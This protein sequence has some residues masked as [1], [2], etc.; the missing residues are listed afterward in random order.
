V[1]LPPAGQVSWSVRVRHEVVD[2]AVMPLEDGRYLLFCQQYPTGACVAGN[3]GVR[4]LR[5]NVTSFFGRA[6]R[7]RADTATASLKVVGNQD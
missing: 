4:S 7:A 6:V 1:A 5:D 3:G 2:V